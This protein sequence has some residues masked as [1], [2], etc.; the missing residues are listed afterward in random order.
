MKSAGSLSTSARSD[1]HFLKVTLPSGRPIRYCDP[2]TRYEPSEF[3][4]DRKV[5]CFWGVNSLSKKWA[6]EKTYGGKL[7]ENIVQ[8]VARDLLAAA[9]PRVE[10]TG[11]KILFHSHDEMVVENVKEKANAQE[12]EQLLSILPP[13]AEGCPVTAEGWVGERYRK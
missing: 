7:T 10:K 6:E 12:L 8:A 1:G 4:E 2:G 5:L 11:R 9:M 13:W 3:G